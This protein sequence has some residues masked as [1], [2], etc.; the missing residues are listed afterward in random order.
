MQSDSTEKI[1]TALVQ[2]AQR[3]I[4]IT[5]DKT[6]QAGGSR[7]YQYASLDTV[8]GEIRKP[9]A[10]CG[11]FVSQTGMMDSDG[12]ELL[13]TTIH[14]VSGEFIRGVQ[15]LHTDGNA[16]KRNDSQAH[17]AAMTY[18]RRYALA[19]ALGLALEDDDDA[20]SLG[21]NTNGTSTKVIPLKN[22]KGSNGKGWGY[23][24][25]PT[26]EDKLKN[27]LD[28][29]RNISGNS[30]KDINEVVQLS[31]YKSIDECKTSEQ[32]RNFID[33][34]RTHM[35]TDPIPLPGKN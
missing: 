8:I 30:D 13:A 17:G 33:A 22:T 16:S 6:A 21:K 7:K 32:R 12:T 35:A 11:L 4:K 14:H 29:V 28:A 24:H 27:F 31:G 20:Q 9:L 10:E 15:P 5:K 1:V 25:K 23:A 3:D 18:S 26:D 34:L 19:A 2:F